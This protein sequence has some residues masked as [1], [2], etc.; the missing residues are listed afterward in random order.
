MNK[1]YDYIIQAASVT[2]PVGEVGEM[3][4]IEIPK[5]IN[6]G[7]EEV[8]DF[9]ATIKELKD[10]DGN[11]VQNSYSVARS[12]MGYL[13]QYVYNNVETFDYIDRD[14][15][16]LVGHSAGGG[17]AAK[18]TADFAG[19]TYEESIVKAL[20]ISGYIK[21]S[22]ANVF[23][24][25][26]CN[27]A[28]SY[29]KYDEG[30]FRYQDENQ[31]YEVIALR[32][33][34]EVNS[35]TNGANGKFDFFIHDYEYGSIDKGT[36]RVIHN[37]ETNHCFEMYDGKSI[38]NTIDFFK[39]SLKLPSLLRIIST[40]LC[41]S[42]ATFNVETFSFN[43][44]SLIELHIYCGLTAFF[45]SKSISLHQSSISISFLIM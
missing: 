30:E 44:I 3:Y 36:Y 15:I 21:T 8:E 29:A 19:A 11:K 34:N 14:L 28:M 22:A 32:F 13:L 5:V 4:K 42:F 2:Q 1:K 6:K 33:V 25:L 45:T 43:K 23:N 27:T 16:G 26:R 37:E 35:K 17:D 31:A 12:G 39:K 38:A 18:L 20:Y 7:G 9:K 24:Q 10:A 41:S 40:Y